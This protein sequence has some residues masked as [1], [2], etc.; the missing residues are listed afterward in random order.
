MLVKAA[1]LFGFTIVETYTGLIVRIADAVATGEAGYFAGPCS[2]DLW[3]TD[4]VIS[5]Y[6]FTLCA[7][8]ACLVAFMPEP[9][10][11]SPAHSPLKQWCF[12]DH[13]A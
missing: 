4:S 5:Q 11:V 10:T 7:F 8:A 12:Y 9:R 2:A 6:L 1:A 3:P 13:N